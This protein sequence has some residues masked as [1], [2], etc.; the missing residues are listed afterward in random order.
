M[1]KGSEEIVSG[2]LNAGPG[3]LGIE[4]PALT[5]DCPMPDLRAGFRWPTDFGYSAVVVDGIAF[6]PLAHLCGSLIGRG[7]DRHRDFHGSEAGS[8]PLFP[9][10]SAPHG[11]C[12]RSGAV[13]PHPAFEADRCGAHRTITASRPSASGGRLAWA[14][15]PPG[16]AISAA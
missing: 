5:E 2:N 12:S 7:L 11:L 14:L 3:Y 4:F 13:L 1:P 9:A 6:D 8:R 15:L 16:Q 10:L